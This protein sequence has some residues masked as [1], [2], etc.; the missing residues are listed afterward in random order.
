LAIGTLTSP[1]TAATL[2]ARLL[3]ARLPP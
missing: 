1:N 3:L 2:R